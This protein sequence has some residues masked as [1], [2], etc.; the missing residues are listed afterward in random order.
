MVMVYN[1]QNRKVEIEPS[2]FYIPGD[3]R[4]R[5]GQRF[6]QQHTHKDLNRY[7][8]VPRSTRKCNALS[9]SITSATLGDFKAGITRVPTALTGYAYDWAEH[10]TSTYS[11]NLLYIC[12]AFFWK[13][14]GEHSLQIV[15]ARV[16]YTRRSQNQ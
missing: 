11:L 1:I 6:R 8:F 5:R 7:S 2:R 15:L 4:T 12:L 14:Y 3:T 16:N 10:T 9:D 13:I